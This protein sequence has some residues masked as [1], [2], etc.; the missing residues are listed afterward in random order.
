MRAG[1][2]YLV[3]L[4]T[5]ALSGLTTSAAHA[6]NIVNFGCSASGRAIAAKAYYS[7]P[8]GSQWR[9]DHIDYSYSNSGGGKSDS[10]FTVNNGSNAV[11][12]TWST[13]DNRD[14]GDYTKNVDTTISRGQDARAH[15]TTHF[16]RFGPD[17]SCSD[18]GRF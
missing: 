17:P 16:D 4:T 18:E 13:P 5:I 15:Q 8:N 14:D 9:V 11:A 6:L 3:V 1:S 10:T 12:W 7:A 2:R